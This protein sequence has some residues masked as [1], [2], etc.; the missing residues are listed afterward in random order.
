MEVADVQGLAAPLLTT[1]TN[2]HHFRLFSLAYTQHRKSLI[3]QPDSRGRCHSRSLDSDF[4][5]LD[6]GRSRVGCGPFNRHYSS[7][8]RSTSEH[9]LVPRHT[10]LHAR[11][12]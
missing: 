12:L 5:S 4:K 3:R 11:T 1:S 9:R 2:H 6:V 8:R 7:A 10:L